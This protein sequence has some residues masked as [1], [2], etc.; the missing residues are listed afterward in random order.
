MGRGKH[1]RFSYADQDNHFTLTRYGQK[2]GGYQESSI[3]P[4]TLSR[5]ILPKKDSN[6]QA[7]KMNSRP[8]PRVTGSCF[9]GAVRYQLLTPPLFCYA[10]HCSDC[11][12]ATGSVFAC[13]TTIEAEHLV[14]IGATTPHLTRRVRP[15]GLVRVAASCPQCGTILWAGGDKDPVTTDVRTGT[16]DHPELMEPD[17]HAYI[18]S[19]IPWIELPA[20]ARTCKGAYDFRTAW[21]KSSLKRFDAAVKRHEERGRAK[22]GGGE[23]V[24]SGAEDEKEADKTPTA[25]SPEGKEEDDDEAFEERYRETERALQERL[26]KL[27]LKLNEEDKGAGAAKV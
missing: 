2:L 27:T 23:G 26:E 4:P 12:K 8:F 9:C 18:E 14:S 15:S 25:Q 24:G 19:K 1:L 13:F 3:H 5:S 17:L 22:G 21:P 7:L 20:G 11:Q 16:L 6:S 10:C